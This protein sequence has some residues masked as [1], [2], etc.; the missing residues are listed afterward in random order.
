MKRLFFTLISTLLLIEGCSSKRYYTFGNTSSI[1]AKEEYNGSIAV[2]KVGLPKYL[3]DN[4]LVRQ[5]TP[6]QVELI[7]DT[8]WLTPMPKHLTNVL[9]SYLQKSLNNPNVHLYPWESD[10]ET[11]KRLSVKI[12]RFISYNNEV[13]LD[14]SYQIDNLKTKQKDTKLFTTRIKAS[15]SI[16]SIVEAME[17][18]YFEL[19]E[20]IKNEIIK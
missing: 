15:S 7:K 2:E 20:E 3:K 9:I 8:N 6:Y 19:S 12:K 11:Q 1:E 10:K 4:T 18:A 17:E 16:E 5:V 13:I 14:A